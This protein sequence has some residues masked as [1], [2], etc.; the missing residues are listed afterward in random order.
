MHRCDCKVG[1][2]RVS[3]LRQE[4]PEERCIHRN[5]GGPFTSA[6]SGMINEAERMCL[7]DIL[8]CVKHKV[9]DTRYIKVNDLKNK[10][11]G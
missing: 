11:L 6:V 8:L 10:D 7:I 1:S 3:A 9:F 5:Q 2:P 4:A